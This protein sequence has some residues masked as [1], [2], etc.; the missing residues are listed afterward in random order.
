MLLMWMTIPAH[1]SFLL[2]YQTK[3]TKTQLWK[4]RNSV[5]FQMNLSHIKLLGLMQN[6]LSRQRDSCMLQRDR[7]HMHKIIEEIL[8]K[9][10]KY[11]YDIF[12]ENSLQQRQECK[13]QLIFYLFRDGSDLKTLPSEKG[14]LMCNIT[15]I[16]GHPFDH[17]AGLT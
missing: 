16:I 13:G 17:V 9:L 10:R 7:Q 3:R 15:R 6:K 12:L 14:A 11:N 5:F 8:L 4:E 1:L 2:I